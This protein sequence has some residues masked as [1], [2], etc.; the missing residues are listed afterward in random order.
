MFVVLNSLLA[1]FNAVI[2]YVTCDAVFLQQKE[3][4]LIFSS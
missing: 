4:Y 2:N 3:T 1:A